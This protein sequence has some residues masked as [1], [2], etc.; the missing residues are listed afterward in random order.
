MRAGAKAL[1]PVPTTA[2]FDC[3]VLVAVLSWLIRGPFS[4]VDDPTGS[5]EGAFSPA[6]QSLLAAVVEVRPA[7]IGISSQLFS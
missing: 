4:R 7:M 1:I 2:G 6:S 3:Q 5:G